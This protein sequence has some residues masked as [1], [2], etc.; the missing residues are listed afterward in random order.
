MW[1]LMVKAS[2]KR[3][4]ASFFPD[5]NDQ[6]HLNM[7]GIHNIVG[8]AKTSRGGKQFDIFR[9]YEEPKA[10]ESAYGLCE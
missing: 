5:P 2:S 6:S 4:D 3:G 8:W 1:E 10:C 9:V 7:R